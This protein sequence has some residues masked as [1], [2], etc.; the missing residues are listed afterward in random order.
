MDPS[1]IERTYNIRKH[2]T[3]SR[4]L[5]PDFIDFKVEL[6][7]YQMNNC[8]ERHC[9]RTTWINLRF[10]CDSTELA[11][12][13]PNVLRYLFVPNIMQYVVIAYYYLDLVS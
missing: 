2:H 8:Y 5:E 13:V 9:D 4:N 10:K 11:E 6:L 1:E 12:R 3:M 7:Q